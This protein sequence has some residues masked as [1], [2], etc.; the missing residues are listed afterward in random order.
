MIGVDITAHC[1]A[2][3]VIALAIRDRLVEIGREDVAADSAG[4]YSYGAWV[5]EVAEV[6][7]LPM[8][9]EI[10]SCGPEYLPMDLDR[11]RET[12]A[13]RDLTALIAAYDAQKAEEAEERAEGDAEGDAIVGAP[14]VD[15]AAKPSYKELRDTLVKIVGSDDP[16]E[17]AEMRAKLMA[18]DLEPIVIDAIDVLIAS[19]EVK[20]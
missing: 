9:E 7:S 11:V 8:V 15:A 10:L 17:L 18:A 12:V 16:A 4:I 3:A 2:S 19:A 1:H 13:R 14:I 5:A 6:L 20:P